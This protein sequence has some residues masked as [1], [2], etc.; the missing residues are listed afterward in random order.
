M[1]LTLHLEV[2]EID[3]LA[4]VKFSNYMRVPTEVFIRDAIKFYVEHITQEA[5]EKAAE[6]KQEAKK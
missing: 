2:D 5:K 4:I 1:K 6:N 3:Y